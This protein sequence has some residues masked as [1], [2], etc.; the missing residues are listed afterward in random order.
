MSAA[1]AARRFNIQIYMNHKDV[2]EDIQE[3]IRELTYTEVATGETDSLDIVL[4]DEYNKWINEWLIDKGMKL[5]AKIRFSD[6]HASGD[7]RI[8]DCGEHL[9]DSLKIKGYP[10]E[11]TIKS[12]AV[13]VNGTKN[14]KKWENISLSAIARDICGNLGCELEYYGDDI[15]LKSQQQSQQTDINFLFRLCSDYGK[16]MKVHKNKIV[17]YSREEQDAAMPVETVYIADISDSFTINDNAEGMYTGVKASYKPENSDSTAEYTLGSQEKVIVLENA[18]S[19]MQEAEIKAK[20][21]LYNTNIEGVKLSFTA[22][23]DR[24]FYP[25]TNY[26]IYGM[27][28]YSGAYA[29]ERVVHSVK[30]RGGYSMSVTAHAIA[31]EKDRT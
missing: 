14:T 23:G 25:G 13:P 4:Y 20:A 16:G 24:A 11:V 26:Y 6:W 22:S 9:C 2:T 31:L 21:A 19:T 29:I 15:V 28:L 10:L 8:L 7:E 1:E 18:G 12:V 27:G 3:Y 5:E 17:I 30:E